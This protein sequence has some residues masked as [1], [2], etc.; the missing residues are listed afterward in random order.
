MHIYLMFKLLNYS[1]LFCIGSMLYRMIEKMIDPRWKQK[2]VKIILFFLLMSSTNIIVYPGELS[3]MTGVFLCFLA[4]VLLF[5]RGEPFIKLSVVLLFYPI[6]VS[7]GYIMEDIGYLIWSH[8]YAKEMSLNGQDMLHTFTVFLRMLCWWGIYRFTKNWIADISKI[9]TLRMWMVIDLISLTSLTGLITVIY[10]TSMDY[11]YNAYPVCGAA[12]IASLLCCFLCS[13][14]AKSVRM[15]MEM[16]TLKYQQAYYQELEEAQQNVRRLRHDM[17]NH[18]SIIQT[19]FREENIIEAEKYLKE[20]SG[21]FAAAPKVFCQNST[22]NAV[23]SAKYQQ[24]VKRGIKCQFRVE[25]DRELPVTDICLCSIVANTLDNAIEANDKIADAKYRSMELK[26]RSMNGYLS[27]E[28]TN[29]KVNKIRKKGERFLSDKEDAN[30]HGIGIYSIKN[31]VEEMGGT[32][33][34]SYTDTSFTVTVLL[35]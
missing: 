11:S 22:V 10:N 9:L 2:P 3:G 4:V 26:M 18:L 16:E 20:V 23:L 35:C 24:V 6:A 1:I 32:F 27:Y 33:D 15:N 19:L 25:L 5:F 7:L 30:S 14:L 21:E 31:M 29:A 12:I 8:I 13:Y 17:K 28:I 34:V